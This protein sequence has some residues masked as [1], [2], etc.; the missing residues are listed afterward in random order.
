IVTWAD[1][2]DITYPTPLTGTQL[3]ATANVPGTFAYTPPAG[4][5]LNPGDGQPLAVLL[6]PTDSS[7]YTTAA[8]QV[9][10]KVLASDAS[11]TTTTDTPAISVGDTARYT[12]VVNSSGP[13]SSSNVVLTD[14]LPA[15]LT[16]TVSGSDAAACSPASPIVGG[17]T[18]TCNFGTLAAGASK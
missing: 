4:T 1:P 13:G 11:V 14:V 3:N 5:V 9:H 16:W 8:A 7:N 6:T 15:G 17:A 10:I 18:L 12:L 2:A